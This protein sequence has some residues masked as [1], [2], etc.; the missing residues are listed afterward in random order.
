MS[1]LIELPTRADAR[2]ALTFIEGGRHIPFPLA[3]I[4][5]IYGVAPGYDRGHHA[6]RRCR[7]V[8]IAMSGAVTVAIEDGSTSSRVRLDSP[9]TGLL[10][11]PM[12]WHT[13]EDFAPG[14]ACLVLA[15]QRYDEADYIRDHD[16]F[17]REVAR[18]A[19]AGPQAQ[20]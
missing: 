19:R 12:E 5:L 3:R 6:H 18:D 14:T 20:R 15:S 1:R 4:F 2:G 11:E 16:A 7:Q 8:V 17:R 13:L 9:M 10:I